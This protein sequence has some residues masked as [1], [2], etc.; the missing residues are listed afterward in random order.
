MNCCGLA[1]WGTMCSG[2][3]VWGTVGELCA[4][5]GETVYGAV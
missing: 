4:C 1:V 2:N 3:C 5:G